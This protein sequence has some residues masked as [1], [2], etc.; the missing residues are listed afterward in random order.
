MSQFIFDAL[1]EPPHNEDKPEESN[2]EVMFGWDN[3]LKHY[4]C[5]VFYK[6]PT[7]D[8]EETLWSSLDDRE[9]S[10]GGYSA[11]E[12]ILDKLKSLDIGVPEPEHAI[13]LVK[14]NEGNV[15]YKFSDCCWKRM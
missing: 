10:M 7:D 3:P 5:T 9:A 14:L 4:F 11:A 1:F 15:R 8:M 13:K 2:L 12:T 6:N